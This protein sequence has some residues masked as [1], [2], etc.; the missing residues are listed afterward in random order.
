MIIIAFV[1]H[2]ISRSLAAK[3]MRGVADR[4]L[5]N[6]FDSV[7][8]GLLENAVRRVYNT[9]G[10]RQVVD[11]QSL[12]NGFYVR[13]FHCHFKVLCERYKMADLTGVLCEADRA[14]W[15]ARLGKRFSKD[16]QFE[17]QDGCCEMRFVTKDEKQL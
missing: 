6:R 1:Y 2:C 9:A 12:D 8:D 7:P 14:Y 13:T 4:D 16:S 11:I 10:R 15:D 5:R 3:L 17:R